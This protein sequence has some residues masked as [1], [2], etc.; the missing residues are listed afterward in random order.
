MS[1]QNGRLNH[2][3]PKYYLALYCIL[4]I[5]WYSVKECVVIVESKRCHASIIEYF[6]KM[7]M[8][9]KLTAIS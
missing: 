1:K 7:K 6:E 4:T 3:D 8:A 2:V 5:C 9:F